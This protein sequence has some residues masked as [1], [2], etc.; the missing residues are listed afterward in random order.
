MTDAELNKADV[1]KTE[2]PKTKRQ[3]TN[4]KSNKINEALRNVL[5]N[6]KLPDNFKE[7]MEQL[8]PK[9]K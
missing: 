6:A 9:C 5:K 2:P 3:P 7:Q 4:K 1:T 8:K